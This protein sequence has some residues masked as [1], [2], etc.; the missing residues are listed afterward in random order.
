ML[1]LF[2]RL[3]FILLFCSLA[4]LDLFIT[5]CNKESS[6]DAAGNDTLLTNIKYWAY[7]IDS[8]DHAGCI[9]SLVQSRYD[10]I[11]M[12]QQR[13]IKGSEW[14]DTRSDVMRIK[15][16]MNS[17]D[18]KKLVLCY[19]NVGQAERYRSY[20][21]DG[22]E[23]GNPEWIMEPDPDGW[24]DNYGVR[25]WSTEWKNIMK[26]SIREIVNDGFDGIYLDWLMIYEL[27]EIQQ[28][29]ILEGL[30]ARQEIAGFVREI[31][32]Y[33]RQLD[34]DFLII[35]QNAAELVA[36]PGYLKVVNGIAQEH[37][38]FDGSGDP[39]EG[40]SEGDVTVPEEDSEYVIDILKSWQ[41][42]GKLVFNV[43]YALRTQ[44]QNLCYH[45]TA[46]QID[47]NPASGYALT[48]IV[49]DLPKII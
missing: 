7:L 31:S 26:A 4:L 45:S 23:T 47:I 12:D 34:E 41:Q 48:V 43:E 14:H 42:K 27:P 17:S 5:S 8:L 39:D 20:W 22:W 21:Q 18:G 24:N 30:N 3:T 44:L 11:V 16:S 46:Q 29:A 40:G 9:E 2:H 1:Y 28:A 19:I 32:S 6:W 33:A 36:E 37:I 10:L 49:P 25:F 15:N 35:G 13:S 38:W